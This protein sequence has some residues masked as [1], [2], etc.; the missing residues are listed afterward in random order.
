MIKYKGTTL[1]PPAMNNLL[2]NFG[3]VESYV[4]E[5]SHNTIGTDEILI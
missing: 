3:E 4:I 2:N 1:Y 5:I